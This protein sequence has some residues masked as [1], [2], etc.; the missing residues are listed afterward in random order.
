VNRLAMASGTQDRSSVR[1]ASER[2]NNSRSFGMRGGRMNERTKAQIAEI[3]PKL[4]LLLQE[5]GP[6]ST[7]DISDH[8][9]LDYNVI[10]TVL[11]H[12]QMTFDVKD[13]QANN[14]KRRIVSLKAANSCSVV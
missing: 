4:F 9:K 7:L 12:S 2:F 8:L 14:L 5:K 3:R 10:G 11:R 13:I 1:G 6:M